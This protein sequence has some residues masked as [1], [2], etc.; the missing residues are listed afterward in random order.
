MWERDIGMSRPS[1]SRSEPTTQ[2]TTG[3]TGP[4]PGA[5]TTRSQPE[6]SAKGITPRKKKQ[7]KRSFFTR[8]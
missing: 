7:K 2:R 1:T 6:T 8:S 4:I 3:S 5:S